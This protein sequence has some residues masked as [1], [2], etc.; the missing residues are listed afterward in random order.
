MIAYDSQRHKE[1]RADLRR[2]ATTA[3][4]TQRLG[5]VPFQFLEAVAAGGR[6]PS[7]TAPRRW[8]RHELHGRA[9]LLMHESGVVPLA[10]LRTI[11]HEGCD[12][13]Q[14]HPALRQLA[15]ERVAVVKARPSKPRGLVSRAE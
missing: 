15:A 14:A 10:D 13:V 6:A 2:S 4:V 12:L 7:A 1:L 8:L 9:E 5:R 11:P 3:C